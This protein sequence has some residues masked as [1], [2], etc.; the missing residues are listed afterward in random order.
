MKTISL[1]WVHLGEIIKQTTISLRISLD[2]IPKNKEKCWAQIF[3]NNSNSALSC[4]YRFIEENKNLSQR[5]RLCL[6]IFTNNSSIVIKKNSFLLSN[7]HLSSLFLL[8]DAISIEIKNIGTIAPQPDN[9][10]IKA[11][12]TKIDNNENGI[13]FFAATYKGEKIIEPKILGNNECLLLDNKLRLY[14]LNAVLTPSEA[15]SILDSEILPINALGELDVNKTFENISSLGVDF[16]CLKLL[17]KNSNPKEKIILR[18]ILIAASDPPFFALRAHLVTKLF[19]ENQSDEVEIPANGA[20]PLIFAFSNQNKNRNNTEINTVNLIKRSTNLEEKAR[21]LLF[22]LGAKATNKH[23]GFVINGENATILLNKIKNKS[24]PKWLYIDKEILPQIIHLPSI[25]K[26]LINYKNNTKSNILTATIDL[27]NITTK[28]LSFEMIKNAA[29]NGSFCILFNEETIITFDKHLLYIL[30][31]LNENLEFKSLHSKEELGIAQAAL[32]I[33]QLGTKINLCCSEKLKKRLYL[34]N[35]KL[36]SQDLS[37]PKMLITRLRPYQHDALAWMSQLD[38][39]GIGR[40]L[41]DDMGLGKTL[42]VLSLLAKIKERSKQKINLV[43]APTSVIDVWSQEAKSHLPGLN[44]HIWH[45]PNRNKYLKIAK[46]SDILITS[47]ATLRRDTDYFSKHFSFRYLIIDEAQNLK[48]SKTE[49]WKAAKKIKAE[50]KIALSGTPIENRIED[51]WSIIEIIAPKVLGSEKSFQK[52][53][54]NKIAKGNTQKINELRERIKPIVLRRRKNIVESDL[55]DKIE[56]IIRCEMQIDQRKFYYNIIKSIQKKISPLLDS[57]NSFKNRISLL[58]ALTHLRQACCDP[59]LVTFQ[60]SENVSCAKYKLLFKILNKCFSMGRRVIIY[61]QFVKMQQYIH[62]LLRKMNITDSLWL[63]GASKKRSEI[64]SKFQD[65]NGP[66]V[67]VV[68]LKAGGTG[69][70]LTAADTIIF[71]DPWWN[72]AVEEQASDRAHRIGQ[73]KTV[74]VIKLICKNCI[75]EQILKLSQSKRKIADSVL[76]INGLGIKNISLEDIKKL[77]VTEFNRKEN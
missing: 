4:P 19:N 69:I 10:S 3:V 28:K 46:N 76:T 48:N 51:L 63:H 65:L 62:D 12:L 57:T 43:I 5:Q 47:Y 72:P 2:K 1:P 11:A 23:R 38:R 9:S 33:K 73:T 67:I 17:S 8:T 66:K 58:A 52:N 44:V 49:N 22:N 37:L 50:Q 77:L 41:A 25:P 29:T 27:G 36:T 53:Y 24:L 16:S 61:S 18:I 55:P 39:S 40:L 60:K 7:Y 34:F 20:L 15:K 13:Y 54:S 75:E 35:S 68:S 45:G 42:M 14:R 32:L 26:L 21:N 6:D 59:R 31:V 56:S 64:I 71:Y 30:N 74:H 70:T